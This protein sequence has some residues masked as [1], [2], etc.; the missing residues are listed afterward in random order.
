MFIN[1]KNC[2]ARFKDGSWS[3][4]IFLFLLRKLSG[5]FLIVLL[6][7]LKSGIGGCPLIV[8]FFPILELQ[9]TPPPICPCEM[10][11]L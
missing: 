5:N 11:V 2:S 10:V 7:A 1:R 3:T 9:R 8:Q 6:G 4:Y